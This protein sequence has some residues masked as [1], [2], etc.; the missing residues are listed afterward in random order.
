MET[1]KLKQIAEVT[2]LFAQTQGKLE[3]IAELLPENSAFQQ[4]LADL[5]D[6]RTAFAWS[7][8]D[9]I[10]EQASG[11]DYWEGLAEKLS[12]ADDDWT[13]AQWQKLFE[14]LK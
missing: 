8:E 14:D 12:W 13:E 4:R 6:F 11:D 10:L 5:N 1:D 3:S 2:R 9:W 7:L